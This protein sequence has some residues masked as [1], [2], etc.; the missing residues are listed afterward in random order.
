VD[1]V[2]CA[3]VERAFLTQQPAIVQANDDVGDDFHVRCT[4]C[5]ERRLEILHGAVEMVDVADRLLSAD[6]VHHGGID[7]SRCH[8]PCARLIEQGGMNRD[9]QFRKI[10]FELFDDGVIFLVLDLVAPVG[11]TR[12]QKPFQVLQQNEVA[13]FSI[14]HFRAR[15]RYHRLEDLAAAM[16]TVQRAGPAGHGECR[17]RVFRAPGQLARLVLAKGGCGE[18][19]RA[20]WPGAR[21][22]LHGGDKARVEERIL[23]WFDGGEAID[24]CRLISGS[25]GLRHSRCGRVLRGAPLHARTHLM[26][27]CSFTCPPVTWG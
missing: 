26:P 12:Q 5:S 1:V 16:V 23:K 8:Q 15:C 7:T 14:E 10:T 11:A 18:A 20:K 2:A 27:W 6:H 9:L 3:D 21:V 24:P 25:S 13:H 22:R 19:D 4:Q 17:E